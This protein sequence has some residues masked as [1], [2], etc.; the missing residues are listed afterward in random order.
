MNE[1][2]EDTQSSEEVTSHTNSSANTKLTSNHGVIFTNSPEKTKEN[3]V[4]AYK[5]NLDWHNTKD[6]ILFCS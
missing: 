4:S 6:M 5:I 1:E 2:D 3:P